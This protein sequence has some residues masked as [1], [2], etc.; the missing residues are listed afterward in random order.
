MELIGIFGLSHA[1][2]IDPVGILGFSDKVELFLKPKLGSRYVFYMAKAI[3]ERVELERKLKER[4]KTDFSAMADFLST[5]VRTRHSIIV[6]SDFIE[7]MNDG[8]VVDPDLL[9]H[10]SSKHDI[11]FV[12][13]DDPGE[14]AAKGKLGYVRVSNIETGEQAVISLRKLKQINREIKERRN[15]LQE[16]LVK[17]GIDS[18][19]LTYGNHLF[20]LNKFFSMRR[21]IVRN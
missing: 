3:F 16:R 14:F 21:N 7:F 6:I 2:I 17:T 18:V 8:S 9:R 1:H 4:R 11:L 15:K 12:F 5:R 20:E 10:L 19:V 13:L